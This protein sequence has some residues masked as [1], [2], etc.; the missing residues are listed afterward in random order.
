MSDE[1]KSWSEMTRPERKRTICWE[2][3]KAKTLSSLDNNSYIDADTMEAVLDAVCEHAAR[4]KLTAEKLLSQFIR[5]VEDHFPV[6]G[7]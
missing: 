2:E 1:E 6:E 5:C 7:L 4:R 3:A